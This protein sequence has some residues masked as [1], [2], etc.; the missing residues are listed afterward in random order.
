MVKNRGII[1]NEIWEVWNPQGQPIYKPYIH[2]VTDDGEGLTITLSNN[3]LKLQDAVKINFYNGASSSSLLQGLFIEKLKDNLIQKYGE[4]F[5]QTSSCF[6]IR[7]SLY[8]EWASLQSYEMVSRPHAQHFC[9]F[10]PDTIVHLIAPYEPHVT[11][12]DEKE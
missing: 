1:M 10:T 5:L 12:L 11:F 3:T 9:I 6:K 8:V 7:N 2:S 4:A